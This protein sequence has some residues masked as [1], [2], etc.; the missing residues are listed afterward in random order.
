MIGREKI[1]RNTY[2][3]PILA[4][5]ILMAAASQAQTI[6]PA[7]VTLKPSQTQV[8]YVSNAK[9]TYD[10]SINPSVGSISSAGLYTAPASITAVTTVTVDAVESGHPELSATVTL[11]P[12][13]GISVSPTWISLTNGQS[14]AFTA[15]ISGASNT[16][17]TWS[18]PIIGTITSGGVYTVPVTLSASQSITVTATSVV[19]PTKSASATIALV[20]T[21]GVALNPTSTSLTAGQS[22]ALNAAVTGTTNTGLN[23]SLSPQVGTLSGG[24]YTAPSPIP[25]AETVTITATSQASTGANA[26]VTL[27]LVPVSV[28]VTPSTASLTSGQSKTFTASVSGSSNTG[29]TWSVSPSVGTMS[30]GVYTAPALVTTAQSVTVNATS[31]ADSTKSASAVVSLTPSV[32]ISMTPSTASLEAG[33]STTFKATVSGSTSNTS[34]N[35]SMSPSVG[36]L[37]GGVYTAPSPVASAQTVTVTATSAADSTKTVTAKVTLVP[38]AVAVS[39][40]TASL[41]GGQ[42]TTLTATVSGSSNTSV[43]WTVSPAVG[44]VVGGVYTAPA[45][46]ASAQSITVTATSAADA[47]K[48]AS[49]KISLVPVAVAVSPTTA[50]LSGGQSTTLT[51]TVTGTSNSSVNWS[52]SPAVG[53]IVNGVYT[54]P[55]TIASAQTVIA[56]ATSAA[57]PAMAASASISLVASAPTVSISVSPTTASLSAGQSATIVPTVTGSSN[58]SV[59]WSFSPSVGTLAGGV[60]TAPATISTQQ[61][62]TVTATSVASATQ[63]AAAII[64][65]LPTIS[66]AVAPATITLGPSQSQQFSASLSGTSNPNVT[67]SVSPSSVGSFSNGLYQ[68]PATINSQQTVTVTATSSAQPTQSGSAI[69]TLVPTVGTALSPSSI[70]LS[71]G[72]STQFSVTNAGAPASASTV[73]WTLVPPVGNIT[74]GV[75]TAPVSITTLQTIVLTVASIANPALTAQATITLTAPT[76]SATPASNITLTPNFSQPLSGTVQFS[77]YVN[78][79]ADTFSVIYITI[80]NEPMFDLISNHASPFYTPKNP[81]N[82]SLDTTKFLDGSHQLYIAATN[83]TG[84]PDFGDYGP[85][86][87]TIQNGSVPAQLRAGYNELWLTPGQ[88]VALNPAFLNTD[89]TTSSFAANLATFSSASPAIASVGTNGVVTA[90]SLGDTTI[91]AGYPG[92]AP[93]TIYVHVNSQNV[94]PHFGKGGV[95]LSSYNAASSLF[96]R[97][98]FN[99]GPSQLTPGTGSYDPLYPSALKAAQINSLETGFYLSPANFTSSSQWQAAFNGFV[100]NIS[101][102]ADSQDFNIVFIGDEIARGDQAVYTASRGPSASWSPNPITYAFTWLKNMGRG[103]SVEMVDEIASAYSAP[104]PQGT[105]GQPNGPTSISCVNDA[106]TVSWPLPYVMQNGDGTFLITGASSNPNLN[107]PISNLYKTV[108]SFYNPTGGWGGFTFTAT[109]IGTQTFTAETD[110]NLTIQILASQPDGSSGT[111]YVHNDAFQDIR[112]AIT[113]V[114]NHTPIDWPAGGTAPPNNVGAWEGDPNIADYGTI[115]WPGGA[116]ALSSMLPIFQTTFETRYPVLQKNNPVWWEPAA[117]GPFYNIVATPIQV[118]SFTG[119][120]VQFAQPHGVTDTTNKSPRFSL[121]GGRYYIYS[122]VNTTTVEVY[123][124]NAGLNGATDQE[125]TGG[126]VTFADGSTAPILNLHSGAATSTTGWRQPNVWFLAANCPSSAEIGKSFTVSGN[127]YPLFNSITWYVASSGGVVSGPQGQ[128]CGFVVYPLPSGNSTVGTASLIL[129]NEYH[130][131]IS[132]LLT[133]EVDP[134]TVSAGI[135]FAA[136]KGMAGARVYNY[137]DNV[138]TDYSLNQF[139]AGDPN[140]SVQPGSNPFYNGSDSIARWQAMSNAFNLIAEIEPYLLQPKLNSPDYGPFMV[141]GART[142]SY[143][144]MLMMTNWN[145]VSDTETVSLSPYNPSGGA[146]T[147]YRMTATSLTQGSVSGLS[148]QLTFAPGETI[149]FTFPPSS[150]PSAP[151]IASFSASPSSIVAGGSATLSWS[152]SGATSLTIEPVVGSQS[153]LTTGSVSVAPTATTTYT[154]TAMSGAGSVTMQTTVSVTGSGGVTATPVIASALTA[155]GI[156]GTSFSLQLSASNS[157][158]SFSASGLPS[159]L[160]LNSTT[161]LISGTPTTAGTSSVTLNATNS[162]GTGSSATLVIVISAVTGAETLSSSYNVGGIVTDGSTFASNGGL[163]RAGNAYSANLLGSTVVFGGNSFNIGPANAPDA[164]SNTSITL[165]AGQYSTLALLGTAVNGNQASQTF[166]VTYSDGTTS[167]FTQSLSDW[168]VFQNYAG[169]KIAVSMAYRDKS[170]GTKQNRTL[171]LYGYSFALNAAKTVTSLTL[172]NNPNV[173]VLAMTLTG[174]AQ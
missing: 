159:G 147:M 32:S 91:T 87:F 4:I 23:W 121:N 64:T 47:T 86:T 51:A 13:V 78:N 97:S 168:S 140:S 58:T 30:G 3:L 162:V 39:P 124:A 167:T 131:G 62:V 169:E 5:L 59:T 24:V 110:P 48:S 99:L 27:S 96:E 19:D 60:Y 120:T 76:S 148:A 34:V 42:S 172:P 68:A 15:N 122:V 61:T 151:V 18:K 50:S 165:P 44:T 85:V 10:W 63:S 2:R 138:D 66:V 82:Y 106:C 84:G 139:F 118:T 28:G 41:T 143:G 105:L 123:Q 89:N 115:Y 160:S 16:A 22:T 134:A 156:V 9:G 77:M 100:S 135:M 69:I 136:E 112:S 132:Q 83:N 150:A 40:T 70:S 75:Y 145:E 95:F 35:W 125:G 144:N 155:S 1:M 126:T 74:N 101:N 80:D 8:F 108:S 17:V 11:M 149:V 43:N 90:V 146:G 129:D 36:T 161:G 56:T 81:S 21:I 6:A 174:G 88:S 53:T 111:D 14:A 166:K 133:P 72:Q 57:N 158:T 130:P 98:M 26:S 20:P 45:T 38:V 128:Q 55:S 116:F 31:A 157:P 79:P 163:D 109:G 103:L 164:V 102:I 142:S 67:W 141:T 113:A 12:Q 94:T 154:L 153:S 65:L 171:S 54:A 29:V 107:R 46:I 127:S 25:S 49:S 119:N 71:G 173:V 104:L 52:L 37:S 170:N 117:A 73:T 33:Q 92:L 152:V 114:P 7:S 137:S 93:D